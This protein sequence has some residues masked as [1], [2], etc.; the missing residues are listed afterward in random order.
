[1]GLGKEGKGIAEPIS[2]EIKG[3]KSGLGLKEEKKRQISEVIA[4]S[5]EKIRKVLIYN[6]FDEIK[7]PRFQKI[8]QEE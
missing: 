5:K 7:N 1:M 4:S 2:I 3:D 6:F 8:S